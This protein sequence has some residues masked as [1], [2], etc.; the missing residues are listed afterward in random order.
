MNDMMCTNKFL[1]ISDFSMTVTA[2]IFSG[3][4]HIAVVYLLLDHFVS[5]ECNVGIKI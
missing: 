2:L 1:C 3:Q 4:L 5:D